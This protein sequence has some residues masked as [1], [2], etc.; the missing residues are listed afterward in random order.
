MNLNAVRKRIGPYID[1]IREFCEEELGIANDLYEAG[2]EMEAAK[3]VRCVV[4][5]TKSLIQILYL[6]EMGYRANQVKA[7]NVRAIVLLDK[8]EP[9]SK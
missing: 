7:V 4:K 6:Y 2:K 5:I 3:R 1:G 9:S 8:I